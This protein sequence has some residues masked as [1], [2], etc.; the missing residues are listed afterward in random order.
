VS[1]I[2][3]FGI[4]AYYNE[5]ARAREPNSNA[6]SIYVSY[7]GYEYIGFKFNGVHLRALDHKNNRKI[8][9]K[10][11]LFYFLF[12]ANS[13]LHVSALLGHS[14][15][16]SQVVHYITAVQPATVEQPSPAVIEFTT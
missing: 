1:P 4:R 8:T 10:C 6:K 12:Y 9:K 3:D 16:D 7:T 15:G 5:I 14:R 13:L 2:S 11:K